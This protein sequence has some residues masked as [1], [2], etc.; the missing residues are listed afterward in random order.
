[1]KHMEVLVEESR[2]EKSVG[3]IQREQGNVLV[4]LCLGSSYCPGLHPALVLPLG[5][6]VSPLL[7]LAPA[8]WD[9]LHF[10]S[11][12]ASWSSLISLLQFFHL[13]VGS[14]LGVDCQPACPRCLDTG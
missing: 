14:G 7:C 12:G 1:M 3:R 6:R 8:P 5:A 4:W 11:V 2:I 13:N 10:S 9:T